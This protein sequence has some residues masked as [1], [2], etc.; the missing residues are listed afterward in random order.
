M[1]WAP[2]P[3]VGRGWGWGSLRCEHQRCDRTTPLPSPPPQGGREQTEYAARAV[4]TSTRPGL[5]TGKERTIARL[6]YQ[7]VVAYWPYAQNSGHGLL[8]LHQ[9]DVRRVR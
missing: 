8:V 3:L 5:V 4:S 9:D 2:L 6:P 1:R 7:R